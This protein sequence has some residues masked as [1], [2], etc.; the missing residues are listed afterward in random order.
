MGS[1]DPTINLLSL[2]DD[3]SVKNLKYMYTN[4]YTAQGVLAGTIIDN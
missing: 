3:D 4:R 2:T 1:Y